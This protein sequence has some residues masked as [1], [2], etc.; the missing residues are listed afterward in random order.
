MPENHPDSRPAADRLADR[1]AISDLMTGWIHR[2]RQ[3]WDTLATLFHEDATLRVMWFSGRAHDFIEGSRRMAEGPLRTKHFI[4]NPTIAFACDRA[5]VETNAILLADHTELGI[6]ATVHVRFLDR[7]SRRA[8]TW[9]IERRD[10]VYDLGGFT[11]P[12]G[13]AAAPDID[14]DALRE[15]HPREYASLAYLIES[16]GIAVTGTFPIRFSEQE[17]AIL[18]EGHAWLA[19]SG[20]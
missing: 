15:R 6:G 19:Q 10:A 8:G 2:D 20:G 4:G 16:S 7:V 12:F 9:R 13:P 14:A 18:S 3:D 1:Q 17:R 11:Y 5:F